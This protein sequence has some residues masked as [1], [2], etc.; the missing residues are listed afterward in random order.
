MVDSAH[1][2]C[3]AAEEADPEAPSEQHVAS[4]KLVASAQKN[5]GSSK[6]LSAINEELRSSV[7]AIAKLRVSN[8]LPALSAASMRGGCSFALLGQVDELL[9]FVFLRRSRRRIVIKARVECIRVL[10]LVVVG[11]QSS[12]AATVRWEDKENTSCS[13]GNVGS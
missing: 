11:V 4:L 13:K 5:T 1:N 12:D 3:N 7:K 6:K 8:R 10:C 9:E 2:T